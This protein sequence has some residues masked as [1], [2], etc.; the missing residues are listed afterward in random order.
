MDGGPL[1]GEKTAL[2]AICRHPFEIDGQRKCV[3]RNPERKF[4]CSVVP[5]K[6]VVVSAL[7]HFGAHAR[8]RGHQKWRPRAT[9]VFQARI[10][11]LRL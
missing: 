1:V 8:L 5:L 7:D 2:I 4:P 10:I 9:E 3:S 11:V 6:L